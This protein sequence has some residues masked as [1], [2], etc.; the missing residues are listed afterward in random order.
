MAPLGNL[1]R[2]QAT[3]I[4]THGDRK[5]DT[6]PPGIFMSRNGLTAS[7]FRKIEDLREGRKQGD[8]RGISRRTFDNFSFEQCTIL[9]V[10][11]NI[12]RFNESSVVNGGPRY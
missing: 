2:G 9:D 11:R 4:G 8:Y 1:C 10:L 5:Q 3:D 12:I 7:L 6:V